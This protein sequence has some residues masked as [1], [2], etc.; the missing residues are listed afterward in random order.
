MDGASD[1]FLLYDVQMLLHQEYKSGPVDLTVDVFDMG[2]LESA[3]GMYASELSPQSE[4]L[5]IGAEAYRFENTL[6]FWQDR[7]YVKLSAFGEGA[8]PLVEQFARKVSAQIGGTPALP[9]VLSQLPQS[10]RK[11]H[12]EKYMRKD[13]L[14]HGY[15]SPAFAATYTFGDQESQ[16]LVSVAPDAPEAQHRLQLL[17]QHFRTTGQCQ[18]APDLGDGAIRAANSFEGKLI[19]QVR[20]RYL[21][22]LLNPVIASETLFKNTAADL[23]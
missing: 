3:F 5:A 16:L 10:H 15:L 21:V 18:P 17:E 7:Y 20:G 13:P 23:K 12:S 19:A 4:F 14:G 9:A 8:P 1:M 2:T 22:L 6:N 11:L